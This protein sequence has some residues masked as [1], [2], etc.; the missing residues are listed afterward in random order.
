MPKLR[1]PI[2]SERSDEEK[3]DTVQIQNRFDRKNG[4]RGAHVD[5]NAK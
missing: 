1:K 5:T 2:K 3:T 4:N